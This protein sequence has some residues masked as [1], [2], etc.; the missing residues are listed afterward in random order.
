MVSSLPAGILDMETMRAT[1][2]MEMVVAQRDVR[3]GCD[4]KIL[5]C[6]KA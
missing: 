3:F 1:R 2:V 6:G 4:W 5:S